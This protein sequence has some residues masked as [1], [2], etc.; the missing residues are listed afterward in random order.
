MAVSSAC[1]AAYG[2]T[3]GLFSSFKQGLSS[4]VKVPLMLFLT[5]AITLPALHAFQLFWGGRL[6]LTQ[7][8]SI[9]LIGTA[10]MCVL[11][12]ALSTVSLFFLM[13]ESRYD[14]MLVMHVVAFTITGAC[15]LLAVNRCRKAIVQQS[16]PEPEATVWLVR[17]W[18]LLYMFVGAQV[19]Y[20][21]SPFIGSGL[22]FHIFQAHKGNFYVAVARS[23]GRLIFGQ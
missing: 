18:M 21:M 1:G 5:L 6:R 7:T 19:A 11:L 13:S 20:L 3:M 2:L 15:G 17:S 9:A 22:E 23:V 10:T 4:A 14:F 8:L 16:G 12:A